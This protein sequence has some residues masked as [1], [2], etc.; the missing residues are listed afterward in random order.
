MGLWKG[1]LSL[2][3]G[4]GRTHDVSSGFFLSETACALLQLRQNY[5]KLT[6]PPVLPSGTTTGSC[7]WTTAQP[8]SIAFSVEICHCDFQSE[9]CGKDHWFIPSRTSTTAWPFSEL[10]FWPGL[11]GNGMYPWGIVQGNSSWGCTFYALNHT[12]QTDPLK[13]AC[14]FPQLFSWG[15]DVYYNLFTF[16]DPPFLFIHCDS[17]Q[18]RL[19]DGQITLCDVLWPWMGAQGL[20]SSVEPEK[21][22][23]RSEMQG[24]LTKKMV[25]K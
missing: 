5:A 2:P 9:T 6:D 21:Q 18:G 8:Q 14:T 3:G 15:I 4:M 16:K 10:C 24:R 11:V 1:A 20:W 13:R 7:L 23:R 19:Q 12:T 17:Y 25:A 22:G